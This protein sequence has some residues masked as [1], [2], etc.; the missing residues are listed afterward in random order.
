MDVGGTIIIFTQ[1]WNF[2]LKFVLVNP[3]MK[4][5]GSMMF[6]NPLEPKNESKIVKNCQL[7]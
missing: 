1:N 6:L 5:I 3:L 7:Q 2:D 4:K